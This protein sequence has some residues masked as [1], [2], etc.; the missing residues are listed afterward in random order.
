M[1]NKDFHRGHGGHRVKKEADML[2]T[3]NLGAGLIVVLP[4][5]AVNA[6]EA[7]AA[8]AGVAPWIMGEVGRGDRS[9]RFTPE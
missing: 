8:A 4:P 2:R 5:E 3:F 9:V 6:A 7:A 1:E